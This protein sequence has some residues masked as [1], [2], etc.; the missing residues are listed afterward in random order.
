[1]NNQKY[2]QVTLT[3]TE[4]CPIEDRSTED[5]YREYLLRMLEQWVFN[6]Q[7]DV[8]IQTVEY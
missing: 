6:N 2:Y 7:M 3:Y 5:D 1:M 4:D 8:E